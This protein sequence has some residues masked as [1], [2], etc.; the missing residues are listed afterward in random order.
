VNLGRIASVPATP[1]TILREPGRMGSA[2]DDA[3]PRDRSTLHRGTPGWRGA[4]RGCL[5]GAGTDRLGVREKAAF[6]S[7]LEIAKYCVC[8]HLDSRD[9]RFVYRLGIV[10]LRSGGTGISFRLSGM[11]MAQGEAK[12]A[13]KRQKY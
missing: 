13:A 7:R 5:P 9:W 8:R 3:G 10:N 11:A 12:I 4:M 1:G 6:Q 2:S